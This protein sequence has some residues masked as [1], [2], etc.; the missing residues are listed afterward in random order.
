MSPPCILHAT[1]MQGRVGML[2]RFQVIEL[3]E[4][5]ALH[6]QGCKDDLR[7]KDEESS[8]LLP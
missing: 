7:S 2:G 8:C 4:V 1:E 3:S 5:A 6:R